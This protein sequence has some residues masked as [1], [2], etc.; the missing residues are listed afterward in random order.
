MRRA[1]AQPS[2][3]LQVRQDLT[4]VLGLQGK[5]GEAEHRLRE[6][7]PPDQADADLAYLKAV[8]TAPAPVSPAAA[9][10]RSWASVKGSG[11]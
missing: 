11:G 4:L 10:D 9:T 1:A 7:L 3:S 2:A 8:S 5:L 6:D